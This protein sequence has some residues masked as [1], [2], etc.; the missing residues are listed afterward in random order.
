MKYSSSYED[1]QAIQCQL[2]IEHVFIRGVKVSQGGVGRANRHAYLR[3]TEVI[4]LEILNP[5]HGDVVSVQSILQS[6]KLAPWSEE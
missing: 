1:G 6:P 5:Q 4:S 3:L 2:S